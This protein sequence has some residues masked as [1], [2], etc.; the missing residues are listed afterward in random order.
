MRNPLLL[1]SPKPC[2]TVGDDDFDPVLHQETADSNCV[3]YSYDKKH[4]NK[5]S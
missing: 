1:W 4:H 5:R 2:M 3:S